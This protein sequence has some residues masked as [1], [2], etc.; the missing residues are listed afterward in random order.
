[1]ANNLT[2]TE[3]CDKLADLD[4][5]TLVES[6][7]LTARDIVDKFGDEIEDKFDL[8]C[9]LFEGECLDESA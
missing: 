2:F 5:I 8:L 9:K 7:D 1:M 6:L 4:E 3:L